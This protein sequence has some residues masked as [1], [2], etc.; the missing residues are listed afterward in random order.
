MRGVT[1]V[2]QQSANLTSIHEDTSSI[3]GLA[4]WIGDPALP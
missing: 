2:A 4:Q 1:V 3:L